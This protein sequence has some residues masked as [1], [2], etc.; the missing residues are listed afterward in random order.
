MFVFVV[1]VLWCFDVVDW[2]GV[3]VWCVYVFWC[4]IVVF[5]C[6]IDVVCVLGY[7]VVGCECCCVFGYDLWFLWFFVGV[8]WYLLFGVGCV[9]CGWMCGC[10]V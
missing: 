1:F 7:V 9:W 2:F 5:M 10:V 8:V 3:V 4:W 6:G